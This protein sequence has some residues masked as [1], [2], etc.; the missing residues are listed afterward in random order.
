MLYQGLADLILIAHASFVA[1]VLFGGLLAI[2]WRGII[3]LHLPAAAWGTLVEL[4]GWRCPLTPL[5]NWLRAQ[6]GQRAPE[7]DFVLR[8]LDPLLYPIDL[9][10]TVQIIL[11]AIVV[12]INGMIYGWLW[13]W[14]RPSPLRRQADG[15][16]AALDGVRRNS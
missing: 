14:R 6:A 15:L 7:A 11:G 5:E 2:R 13:R 8:Y 16:A 12:I 9:T 1:F 10:R 4:S 3:T